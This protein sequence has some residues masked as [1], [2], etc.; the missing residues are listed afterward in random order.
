MKKGLLFIIHLMLFS[1][2]RA[3][4][5]YKVNTQ[6]LNIREFPGGKAS[7]FGY[8]P[9][10]SNV[11]VIDKTD[12]IWYKVQV[13]NTKGYVSSKYLVKIESATQVKSS[14]DIIER[15][16]FLLITLLILL[17]IG[18]V[19]VL[20]IKP[21]KPKPPIMPDNPNSTIIIVKQKSVIGAIVLTIMFGPFGMLY[22]TVKGGLTMLFLPI[23]NLIIVVLL[24]GADF[25]EIGLTFGVISVVFYFVAYYFICIIWAARAASNKNKIVINQ[26][27]QN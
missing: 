17:T 10:G 26:Y 4:E 20:N 6:R 16:K 3:D 12:P 1:Y 27:S 13:N 15:Y 7:P 22:S 18:F 8:I 9:Y 11:L 21:N 14:S 25:T 5:I 2:C 24:M 23:L 19:S